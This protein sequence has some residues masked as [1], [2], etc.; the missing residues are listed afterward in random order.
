MVVRKMKGRIP[1]QQ[2]Y[3]MRHFLTGLPL[4]L[5]ACLAHAQTADTAA[6]RQ[7]PRPDT[8]RKTEKPPPPAWTYTAGLDGTISAGNLNRRLLNIRLGLAHENPASIWSFSTAPR[9]QY[10]TTNGILQEREAFVDLNTSFFYSQHDVY[11]LVFGAYE[12]SNLRKINR[13]GNVGAGLG[14]RIVGGRNIPSKRLQL[15]VT[16]AIVQETT[17]FA[18]GDNINVR[19]NSTRLRIRADLVP[20]KLLVQNTTFVQPSLGSRNL[21]WNSVSQLVY[22][23]T[24]RLAFTASLDSSYESVNAAGVESSQLNATLGLSFSDSK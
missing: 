19:R 20:G 11:G 10:G 5:L 2:S 17:D 13:R 22:K 8:V 23:A 15:A 1:N 9:F 16:N 21:R 12:Q 18:E 3:R 4:F 24:R 6:K 14:W 7:N